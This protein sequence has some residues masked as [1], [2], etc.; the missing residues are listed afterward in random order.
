MKIT[1]ECAPG[2]EKEVVL[3][4]A[5]LDEEMLWVLSMLDTARSRLPGRDDAGEIELVPPGQVLYCDAVDGKTFLLT[6][7]RTLRADRSL[8]ELE[9]AWGALGFARISKSQL[10]NLHHVNKLRSIMAARVE[11]TMVSGE[12]LIVS[13]HYVQRLKDKLGIKR[14]EEP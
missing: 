12:K 9:M 6:Q 4:C 2:A 10:V 3:R 1:I 7:D 8:A 14:R 11:V 13:R 5:A